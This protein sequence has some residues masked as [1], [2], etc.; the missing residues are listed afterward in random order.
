MWRRSRSW[1][2]TLRPTRSAHNRTLYV[3]SC[4]GRTDLNDCRL[5]CSYL[6]SVVP[7]QNHGGIELHGRRHLGRRPGK[8]NESSIRV[9]S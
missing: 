6:D 5:N 2:S 4:A 1:P 9:G 8:C 7:K 3:T